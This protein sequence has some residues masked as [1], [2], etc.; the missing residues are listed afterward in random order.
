MSDSFDP[1]RLKKTH[2]QEILTIARKYDLPV[3]SGTEYHLALLVFARAL[4]EARTKLKR[5]EMKA[6][7]KTLED[8][9]NAIRDWVANDDTNAGEPFDKWYFRME[10]NNTDAL[11]FG[12]NGT[13]QSTYEKIISEALGGGHVETLPVSREPMAG[14]LKRK[15]IVIGLGYQ[16]PGAQ[17]SRGP[18]PEGVDPTDRQPAP[19]GTGSGPAGPPPVQPDAE[20]PTSPGERQP[21]PIGTGEPPPPPPP[22]RE[23]PDGSRNF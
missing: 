20:P 18:K 19:V 7:I 8:V 12:P 11:A 14:K 1:S 9:S 21:T 3:K 15:C 22:V 10:P 4:D 2:E 23:P 16:E 6:D 17:T 13:Q 5:Y